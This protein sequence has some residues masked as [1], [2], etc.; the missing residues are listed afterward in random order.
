MRPAPLKGP[1]NRWAVTRST[2]R[3]SSRFTRRSGGV[4]TIRSGIAT[5]IRTSLRWTLVLRGA[6]SVL[7]G[8]LRFRALPSR[9]S[10][11]GEQSAIAGT[12]PTSACDCMN[13]TAAR[14]AVSPHGELPFPP[15]REWE[16]A[17][18]DATDPNESHR[19]A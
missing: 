16:V 15:H 9:G 18:Q 7:L 17:C 13:R 19:G 11:T 12:F 8:P 2:D 6:K 10:S 14:A 5:V 4:T 1:G 3:H